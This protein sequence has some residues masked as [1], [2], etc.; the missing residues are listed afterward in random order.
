MTNPDHP[1]N[2]PNPPPSRFSAM[3]GLAALGLVTTGVA[4][5]V[6]ALLT[7]SALGLFAAAL[8]FGVTFV[9]SFR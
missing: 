6:H 1:M 4:G 9:V 2:E 5:L 3:P 8:A 7:A